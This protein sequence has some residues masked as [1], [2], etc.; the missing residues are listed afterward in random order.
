MSERLA[1]GGLT[2]D[3]HAAGFVEAMDDGEPGP[4]RLAVLEPVI[5]AFP[6]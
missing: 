2:E 4:A 3:Q 1:S 6:A 5:N